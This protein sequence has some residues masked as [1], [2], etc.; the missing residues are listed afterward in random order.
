MTEEIKKTNEKE[1]MV[2]ANVVA[3][4]RDLID[5]QN[6]SIDM[7]MQI[8]DKKQ[9]AAYNQRNQVKLPG[10][11]TLRT[12][13]DKNGETKVILGWKTTKDEV[14]QDA[15][16]GRWKEEQRLM[17][18]FEDGT[19]EEYFLMDYVRKY[20]TIGVE[21]VSKTT[22]ETTGNVAF[23]VRRLDNGKEYT[24]GVQFIN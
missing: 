22:D 5:R 10:R 13:E 24:V 12:M 14:Y 6:K 1:P 21:V 4:L 3:E 2:P 7:L 17:V 19:T 23:K 15:V 8:A 9:L 20:K 11:A 18:V 16:T